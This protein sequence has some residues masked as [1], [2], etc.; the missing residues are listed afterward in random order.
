[1]ARFVI[2][3]AS[4]THSGGT[5]NLQQLDSVSLRPQSQKTEVTPA[6]AIDRA[7]ILLA[8]A[9]PEL[10]LT[11][12]DLATPLATVT[13]GIGLDCSSGAVIRYA[14]RLAGSTFSVATNNLGITSGDGHLYLSQLS[15]SQE[16]REGARL[17]LNYMPYSTTGQGAPLTVDDAADFSSTPSPAFNS[18]YFFG[19]VYINSVKV[20]NCLSSRVDFGI[21]LL[22]EASCGSVYPTDCYIQARRPTMS[23]TTTSLDHL[24]TS[25]LFTSL[26]GGTLDFYYFKGVAGGAR[27]SGSNHL[28]V[29]VTAGE[30]SPDDISASN[31][32]DGSITFTVMPTV[33]PTI[34]LTA[35]MP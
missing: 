27:A 35:A 34:S 26:L 15:A 19:P 24:S 8:G 28:K 4:F 31:N 18:L 9:S 14:R 5:M 13:A 32:E 22:P 21:Q 12:A 17:D 30:Y 33:T 11:T 2:N 1:M 25:G 3:P 20:N 7:A 16:G 23:F 6:G 10:T 29:S